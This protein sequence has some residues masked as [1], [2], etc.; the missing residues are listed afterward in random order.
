MIM[1][2]PLDLKTNLYKINT[3]MRNLVKL[4]KSDSSG[5]IHLVQAGY[6]C[7]PEIGKVKPTREGTRE[8]IT[9]KNCLERLN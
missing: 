3:G 1:I 6:I 8:D 5:K 4:Y 2:A 9:C 7:N